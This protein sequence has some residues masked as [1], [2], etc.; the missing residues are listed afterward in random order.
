[1]SE[2]RGGVKST[3]SVASLRLILRQA[4][5]ERLLLSFARREPDPLVVSPARSWRVL[6]VRGEPCPFVASPARS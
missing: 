5:D 3:Q 4:Q 1:M 2:L 6:P